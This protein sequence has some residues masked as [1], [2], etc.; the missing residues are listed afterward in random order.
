MTRHRYEQIPYLIESFKPRVI[1][2]IGVHN[3]RTSNLLI[4][5]ALKHRQRLV[6]YGYDHFQPPT[7]EDSATGLAKKRGPTK[8]R[9]LK[10]VAPFL[11]RADV[12]LMEGP[13]SKTLWGTKIGR[14]IDFALEDSSG[15]TET[16]R[17]DVVALGGAKHII[18]NNYLENGNLAKERAIGCNFMV[19]EL[20]ATILPKYDYDEKLGTNV[21]FVLL[22][23]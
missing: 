3:G 14:L 20:G 10:S 8:Q 6:F 11:S 16:L 17:N 12:F 2:E 1:A 18:C 7:T 5:E 4:S 13:T 15:D 22:S 9:F 23:R 21:Y 19:D